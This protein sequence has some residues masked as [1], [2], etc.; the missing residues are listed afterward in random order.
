MNP[1]KLRETS[2]RGFSPL[3]LATWREKSHARGGGK[4]L[5][6]TSNGFFGFAMF[7]FLV[8]FKHT[9]VGLGGT[10]M[11]VGSLGFLVFFCVF[12]CFA[13]FFCCFLV[14]IL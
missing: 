12:I 3:M 10:G 11:F 8:F 13:R 1:E 9:C 14:R 4:V 2:T 5:K 6:P 7:F